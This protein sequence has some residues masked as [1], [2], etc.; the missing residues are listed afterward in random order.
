MSDLCVTHVVGRKRAINTNT[1][2]MSSSSKWFQAKSV[3][4]TLESCL[5]SKLVPPGW[6]SL[7]STA[8][9]IASGWWGGGGRPNYPRARQTPAEPELPG[10]LGWPKMPKPWSVLGTW[11]P[12]RIC[13]SGNPCPDFTGLHAQN[14]IPTALLNLNDNIQIQISC[15]LKLCGAARTTWLG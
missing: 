7:Q 4:L 2:L 8:Q 1:L 6:L 5:T 3:L 11:G 15:M 10:R 9:K 12:K 14:W 13:G